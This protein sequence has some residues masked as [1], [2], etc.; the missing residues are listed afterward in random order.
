MV[1]N[2]DVQTRV[3]SIC[4]PIEHECCLKMCVHTHRSN[5]EIQQATMSA[6]KVIISEYA[7]IQQVCR[8]IGGLHAQVNFQLVL[9]TQRDDVVE[10]MRSENGT[11]TTT[12]KKLVS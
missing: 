7:Y 10:R 11:A 5:A 9:L 1:A 6:G 4:L 12:S 2:Q 3:M 8:M